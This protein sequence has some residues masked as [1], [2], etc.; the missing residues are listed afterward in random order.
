MKKY[1]KYLKVILVVACLACIS[2]LGGCKSAS[3]TETPTPTPVSVMTNQELTS[4]LTALMGTL[5]TQG[6]AIANLANR[7]GTLETAATSLTGITSDIAALKARASTDEANIAA[8]PNTVAVNQLISNWF[9]NMS[10]NVSGNGSTN[11]SLLSRLTALENTGILNYNLSY[12]NGSVW[13]LMHVPP[14]PSVITESLT[15]GPT[16]SNSS[17][18]VFCS[19]TD[20]NSSAVL[21]YDW[22]ASPNSLQVVQWLVKNQVLWYLPTTFTG[23]PVSGT[24]TITCAVSDGSGG[25]S[26]KSISITE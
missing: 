12:I 11:S 25:N 23:A 9:F 24:Y 2:L 1:S 7:L 21:T 5:G 22:V 16:W 8:S 20:S 10:G 14:V 18:F 4:N 19:A 17:Y 6:G 3:K 26:T 13:A 15:V